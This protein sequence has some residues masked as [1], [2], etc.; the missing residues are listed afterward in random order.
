MTTTP[1]S[2]RGFKIEWRRGLIPLSLLILVV[3]HFGLG[4]PW[5]VL[6]LFCL[7]IPVVYVGY[8]YYLNKKWDAFERNFG[9]RFQRGEHRT[10]LEEYRNERFLRRFGP[11]AEMLSR[12]GL[13]YSALEKYQQAEQA[14]EGAIDKFEQGVP[15]QVYFNLANVKFE[16]GKY[17]EAMKIYLTLKGNSP[18]QRA[19][20]TQMALIDLEKGMRVEQAREYLEEERDRASGTMKDRIEQALAR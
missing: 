14:F 12:L 10:L 2:S 7:W 1:S 8:P 11:R 9:Q 5:W 6:L 13:I 20:R 17:D 19:A 3:L 15:E 16:L 4:A 18:Y